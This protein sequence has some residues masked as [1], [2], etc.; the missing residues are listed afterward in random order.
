[1]KTFIQP[2]RVLIFQIKKKL[3]EFDILMRRES[4]SCEANCVDIPN[5]PYKPLPPK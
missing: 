5:T 4:F 3:S 2:E 1:M